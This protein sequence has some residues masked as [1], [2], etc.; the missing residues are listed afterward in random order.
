MVDLVIDVDLDYDL[1]LD[2][3]FDSMS[4]TMLISFSWFSEP[5]SSFDLILSL[6]CSLGCY[7]FADTA[8]DGRNDSQ[9]GG[10]VS[11]THLTLPTIYSV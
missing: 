10:A 1:D 7:R 4:C 6:W 5:T 8:L 3:A 9:G 2:L 11:Y